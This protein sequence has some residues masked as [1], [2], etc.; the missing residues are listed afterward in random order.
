MKTDSKSS[1]PTLQAPLFEEARTFLIALPQWM[2]ATDKQI[3]LLSEKLNL[4][5]RQIIIVNKR[6]DILDQ[7]VLNIPPEKKWPINN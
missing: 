4:I 5:S 1:K 3:N 6:L 7:V 2:L